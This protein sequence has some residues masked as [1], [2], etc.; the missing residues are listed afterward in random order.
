MVEG[1]FRFLQ[2]F[3][4]FSEDLEEKFSIKEKQMYYI[5]EDV[6]REACYSGY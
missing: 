1:V 6:K 2:D 4:D 3:E 5:I